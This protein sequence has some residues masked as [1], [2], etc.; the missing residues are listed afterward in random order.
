SNDGKV[1]LVDSRT[2]KE[3][4]TTR[5]NVHD[6]DKVI[7]LRLFSDRNRYYLTVNKPSEGE[8]Q[9]RAG[10]WSAAGAGISSAVINGKIYAFDRATGKLHWFAPVVDQVLVLDQF[11]SS[12][13]LLFVAR[14]NQGMNPRAAGRAPV[15]TVTSF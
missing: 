15:T 12:P 11:D 1:T 13:V 9:W 4:L 14:N 3:L 6:L 8:Q 5:I 7:E 2:G 10:P